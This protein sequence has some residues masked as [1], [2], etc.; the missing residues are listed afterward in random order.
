MTVSVSFKFFY[1]KYIL[2]NCWLAKSWSERFSLLFKGPGEYLE[3]LKN[4]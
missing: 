2:K 1:Y 3:Y 4:E